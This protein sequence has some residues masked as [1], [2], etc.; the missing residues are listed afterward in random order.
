M[1]IETVGDVI[2]IGAPGDNFTGTHIG[3]AFVFDADT[4]SLLTTLENPTPT[5]ADGFGASP[6]TLGSGAVVIGAA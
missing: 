4:G 2:V 6:A 3:R 5:F 1:S